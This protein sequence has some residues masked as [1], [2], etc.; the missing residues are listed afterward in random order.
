MGESVIASILF[1]VVTFLIAVTKYLTES[2]LR[3]TKGGEACDRSVRQLVT[4]D[5]HKEAKKDAF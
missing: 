3:L 1:V 5:P 2:N 4:L